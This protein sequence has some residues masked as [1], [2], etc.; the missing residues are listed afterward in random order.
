VTFFRKMRICLTALVSLDWYPCSVSEYEKPV[1]T[2][3]SRKMT[4]LTWLCKRELKERREGAFFC[5]MH[6]ELRQRRSKPWSMNPFCAPTW[7]HHRCSCGGRSEEDLQITALI[8]H[9]SSSAP[10]DE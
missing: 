7:A 3:E 9:T 10:F 4:L 8:L 1:P 5:H 6:C 2:G